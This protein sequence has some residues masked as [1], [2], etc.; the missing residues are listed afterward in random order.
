MNNNHTF[1]WRVAGIEK[2][3]TCWNTCWVGDWD[4]TVTEK[5]IVGVSGKT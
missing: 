2:S 5:G 4:G 3:I 1:R